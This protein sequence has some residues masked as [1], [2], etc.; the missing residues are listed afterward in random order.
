MFEMF[1][2]MELA[3][4]LSPKD[5]VNRPLAKK[6][7]KAV[8]KKQGNYYFEKGAFDN[9]YKCFLRCGEEERAQHSLALRFMGSADEKAESDKA[10]SLSDYQEA[11]D[12]FLTLGF[13]K[14]CGY[15]S[16]KL[17]RYVDAARYY[18]NVEEFSL[19]AKC[20]SLAGDHLQA[21]RAHEAAGELG[22]A[23]DCC[24]RARLY[25]EGMRIFNAYFRNEQGDYERCISAFLRAAAINFAKQSQSELMV[26]AVE[27]YH[28]S[29]GE[30][31]SRHHYP[32]LAEKWFREREEWSELGDF[33]VKR[34]ELLEAVEAYQNC[35]E[36]GRAI[37][38]LYCYFKN[39]TT[40]WGSPFWRG[41]CDDGSI[42]KGEKEES[43]AKDRGSEEKIHLLQTIFETFRSL[44][45]QATQAGLLESVSQ[46]HCYSTAQSEMELWLLYLSNDTEGLKKLLSFPPDF[47]STL[48]KKGP[49]SSQD[50]LRWKWAIM[51]NS[52]LVDPEEK[53][54]CAKEVYY[55]GGK[56]AHR[57]WKGDTLLEFSDDFGVGF[58]DGEA[59]ALSQE[60]ILRPFLKPL[61]V[62][63]PDES[64]G[65][66]PIESYASAVRKW[67]LFHTHRIVD[68]AFKL[69]EKREFA[70][71]E[72]PTPQLVE[73]FISVTNKLLI[74]TEWKLQMG[75]YFR[76][77]IDLDNHE[78]LKKRRRFLEKISRSP[79]TPESWIAS[80]SSSL[81]QS[82][83]SKLVETVLINSFTYLSRKI[84]F[85]IDCVLKYFRWAWMIS[86][87]RRW[88]GL[89]R[90][91]SESA[92]FPKVLNRP[93]YPN[94][95]R[96]QEVPIQMFGAICF[97]ELSKEFPNLIRALEQG[98]RFVRESIPLLNS[99]AGVTFPELVNFFHLMVSLFCACYSQLMN[100]M[101]PSTTTH[102]LFGSKP[103]LVRAVTL[104]PKGKIDRI[105]VYLLNTL[106]IFL[107]E[108][109]RFPH[110]L[111]FLFLMCSDLALNSFFSEIRNQLY[112]LGFN[113]SFKS[114][115]PRG[116]SQAVLSML[117]SNNAGAFRK[118][119]LSY[120]K[121]YHNPF[122]FFMR[123]S[124]S[125]KEIHSNVCL[126]RVTKEFGLR[127]CYE[128]CPVPPLLMDP[129]EEV[130]SK[131]REE[132]G[133]KEEEREEGKPMGGD[134]RE[135]GQ[136]EKEEIKEQREESEE[137]KG[138]EDKEK[139]K[140]EEEKERRDEEMEEEE[141]EEDD[142]KEDDDEEEVEDDEEKEEEE[143]GKQKEKDLEE[144]AASLI[145]RCVREW[146]KKTRE[147]KRQIAAPQTDSMWIEWLMCMEK[148]KVREAMEGK[149]E[150]IVGYFL[151]E[152]EMLGFLEGWKMKK[153]GKIDRKREVLLK[154]VA[155]KKPLWS[156]KNQL[157]QKIEEL[158]EME[159]ER[160]EEIIEEGEEILSILKKLFDKLDL[161]KREE[162]EEKE[163]RELLSSCST[164]TRKVGVFL[165]SCE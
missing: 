140:E 78:L 152:D 40:E 125:S 158:E 68:E 148:E 22:E 14:E 157:V 26:S 118:K 161:S 41:R 76:H 64:G 107:R 52:V 116:P 25:E 154:L 156:L 50:S 141:E 96:N 57:C 106:S 160:G 51:T 19:S 73:R 18:S 45:I 138:D 49:S 101:L 71:P 33:L 99:P 84:P 129:F 7:P 30:F 136:K 98:L 10:G 42:A 134:E 61:G 137:G 103:S 60:S 4:L 120:C 81:V 63:H 9:A 38:S 124:H 83:F 93:R 139:G 159:E 114:A 67:V 39:A 133:A 43:I 77:F 70:F 54:V 47:L 153:E 5:A 69:F 59:V 87:G 55:L 90:R 92:L 117:L 146:L 75:Q 163:A 121:H 1:K 102:F 113:S 82:Q 165:S 155:K 115:L 131:E 15:C 11:L 85:T 28:H 80:G 29:P 48:S 95:F 44:F 147:K 74:C 122:C 34:G 127:M 36:K 100:V 66:V 21:S 109:G 145:Q 20:Y 58:N 91:S 110:R 89:L 164:I 162:F 3:E 35:G 13:E 31:Y 150:D 94:S 62:D 108:S 37:E 23:L 12:L 97:T 143:E 2:K 128:D 65:M 88:A 123:S 149:K 24:I 79:G 104:V 46:R 32:K 111:F 144:E 119:I 8:W 6:T 16:F 132:G 126:V 142:E 151:G 130:E 112:S 72:S 17:S 56:L 105:L 135:K 53:L 86:S 27:S